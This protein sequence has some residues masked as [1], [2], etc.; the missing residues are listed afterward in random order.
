MNMKE[1]KL[2]DKKHK[3]YPMFRAEVDDAVRRHEAISDKLESKYKHPISQDDG[4]KLARE[5]DS[6]NKQFNSEIKMIMYKYNYLYKE[7]NNG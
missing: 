2:L 5:M 3:D 7:V 6:Y 1:Q 4:W